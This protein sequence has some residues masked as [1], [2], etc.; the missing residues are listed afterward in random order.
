MSERFYR[1]PIEKL[2]K[3][4]LDEEKE[5]R[6]FGIHKELFFV[7]KESDPFKMERYGNNT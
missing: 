1:I 6:I 3:W 5:G 7:P 4:I 2:F